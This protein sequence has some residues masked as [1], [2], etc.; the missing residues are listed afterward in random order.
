MMVL[1]IATFL[2]YFNGCKIHI[3]VYKNRPLQVDGV[4]C[5]CVLRVCVTN[6]VGTG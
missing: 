4:C 1:I 3:L 2:T 6:M 5:V